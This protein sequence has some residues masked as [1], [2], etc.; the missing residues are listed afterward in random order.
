MSGKRLD[1]SEG[2]VCVEEMEKENVSR[3]RTRE[4]GIPSVMLLTGISH[5]IYLLIATGTYF[6]RG[7]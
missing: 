2:I 1:L 5:T 6:P 4:R 7:N 3:D